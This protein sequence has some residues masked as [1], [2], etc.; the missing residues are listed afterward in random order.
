VAERGLSAVPYYGLAKGFLTGKYRGGAVID[1]PRA[2]G[3]LEYADERG[4]R[5]LAAAQVI[6]DAHLTTLGAVALG[7]LLTRR[8][9]TAP[10]ASARTVEQLDG[11]VGMATLALTSD[12]VTA[13]DAAS[14]PAA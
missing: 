1:S 9:V 14:V 6:A 13:L 7:W 2:A 12:E 8:T 5:V 11:L 10:I 4:E 3:A